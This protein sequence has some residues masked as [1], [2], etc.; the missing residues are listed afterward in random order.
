MRELEN[1]GVV[2]VRYQKGHAHYK[3]K[4]QETDAELNARALTWF[5][6]LPTSSATFG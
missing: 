3:F 1:E 2:E 5:T 6:G 4:V